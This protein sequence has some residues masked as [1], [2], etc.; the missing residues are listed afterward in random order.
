MKVYRSTDE[1][2]FNF[3]VG[4]FLFSLW[5]G[6]PLFWTLALQTAR[7]DHYWYKRLA[8]GPVEIFW[9]EK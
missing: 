5:Y 2:A 9:R 1:P 3:E 8:I 6:S 4:R 7:D